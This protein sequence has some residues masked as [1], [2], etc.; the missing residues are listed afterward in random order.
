MLAVRDFPRIANA[1]V[2]YQE[3]REGRLVAV[4]NGFVNVAGTL[5]NRPAG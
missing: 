5:E 2:T 1:M 3:V 4:G